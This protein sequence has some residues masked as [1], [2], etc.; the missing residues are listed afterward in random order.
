MMYLNETRHSAPP[1]LHSGAALSDALIPEEEP[2][3]ADSCE[4]YAHGWHRFLCFRMQV[5]PVN[6]SQNLFEDGK[7][8]MLRRHV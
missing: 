7:R 1:C 2:E 4:I 5:G 3:E 6:G 8:H